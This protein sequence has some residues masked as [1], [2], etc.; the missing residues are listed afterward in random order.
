M[1]QTCGTAVRLARRPASSGT[2]EIVVSHRAPEVD[3]YL[4][5]LPEEHRATLAGV[6]EV[7]LANLPR[8]YE[9]G[10]AWGMIAYCVPLSTYPNTYNGQP[11]PIACLTARKSSYSLHLMGV[12]GD[13]DTR[14]WFEKAWRASGKKLDMGQ[15]C[16]RFASLAAVPLDVVGEVIRRIPVH[17]YIAR[18]EEARAATK[19]GQR[20]A[21]KSAS[22][23]EKGAAKVKSTPERRTAAKKAGKKAGTKAGTKAGKKA[24]TKAGKKSGDEGGEESGDESHDESDDETAGGERVTR[25]RARRAHAVAA[26]MAVWTCSREVESPPPVEAPPPDAVVVPPKPAAPPDGRPLHHVL[27][28]AVLAA[29][30][31][32]VVAPLAFASVLRQI[33]RTTGL[34]LPTISPP[35]TGP[36]RTR[37]LAALTTWQSVAATLERDVD[38]IVADIGLDW[39]DR[40]DRTYDRDAAKTEIGRDRN[41]RGNGNVMRVFTPRWLTSR[42][43]TLS[44]AAVVYRA[45]RRDFL[46]GTCGEVRL[47]YRLGYVTGRGD[48]ARASRLPFTVNLVLAV[49]DDAAECQRV[50]SRW[51]S[52]EHIPLTSERLL[53]IVALSELQFLQLETNAQLARFPSDLERVDG[54]NFAGQAIYGLRVFAVRGG[55]FVPIPLENTPDVTAIAADPNKRARLHAFVAENLAAIDVGVFRLPDDLLAT[56]ALSWSTLGSARLANRPFAALLDRGELD[57]LVAGD[58]GARRFVVDGAT[59]LERLDA[60]TCMGCHQAAATAGFHVLGLDRREAGVEDPSAAW[61][62]TDGNRLQIGYSPHFAAEVP[63]RS[64]YLDALAH[65]RMPDRF[66]PHPAAPPADWSHPLTFTHAGVDAPCPLRR[67]AL[68]SDGGWSCAP[69]LECRDLVSVASAAGLFGQ[70]VSPEQPVHAGQACRTAQIATAPLVASRASAWNVGAFSDRVFEEA[71][72]FDLPETGRITA[73]SYNCRPA[74][75]GVPLG[76]VTRHCRAR[77]WSFA[78]VDLAHPTE[79][80]AI[81]GGKGFERMATGVSEPVAFAASVGRGLLDACTDRR[82][83]REDYICQQLPDFLAA[84]SGVD[85]VALAAVQRAGIGFCTPTYFVYQLRLDGHPDPGAR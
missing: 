75:I 50:A 25:A 61:Q 63:R 46:P 54:R 32:D 65:G 73:A 6:R 38:H 35:T 68:G 13:P 62:A 76:R 41:H 77:E 30:D 39:E 4:R 20:A 72:V 58:Q 79:V 84:Q 8:G 17:R 74:R 85:K 34:A 7:I 57:E 53:E 42:E 36:T 18:C 2:I 24:R 9:E 23:T 70:C 45:D 66:R 28:T 47:I 15:A 71:L 51:R 82:G 14:V 60:A 81:V 33:H 67:E 16:V 69:P 83:C 27:D 19:A 22:R 12:Y 37:D 26:T 59:L 43:G 44:L 52:S 21:R 5:S 55:A 78:A 80:C 31:R 48:Q 64:A 40:I 11:L 49:P 29:L 3:A 1:T 56:L 10:I